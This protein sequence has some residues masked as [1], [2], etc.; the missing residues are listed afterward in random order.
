MSNFATYAIFFVG[1]VI[2][3]LGLSWAAG[4][5]TWGWPLGFIGGLAVFL[6]AH[7]KAKK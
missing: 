2:I 6:W 7:L 5:S 1:A 3:V 4:W